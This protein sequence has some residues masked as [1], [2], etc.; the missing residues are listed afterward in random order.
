MKDREYW[1]WLESQPDNIRKKI[2]EESPWYTLEA[3]T[4]IWLNR[5]THKNCYKKIDGHIYTQELGAESDEYVW[6]GVHYVNSQL[7]YE[8]GTIQE[9]CD[10]KFSKT[11][12][13]KEIE[14][15]RDTRENYHHAII[16]QLFKINDY[17]DEPFGIPFCWRKNNKFIGRT[18][19]IH[20][21]WI[22]DYKHLI[23]SWNEN[24]INYK[25]KPTDCFLSLEPLTE[26]DIMEL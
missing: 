20:P 10:Y 5:F 16:I 11:E 3:G 21:V 1:S 17:T 6:E 4:H 8:S 9:Y 14:L 15:F 13:P 23:F 24:V 19:C 2:I 7:N 18:V 26:K 22:C 25:W 12:F